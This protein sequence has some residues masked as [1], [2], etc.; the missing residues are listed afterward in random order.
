[1]LLE[2]VAVGSRAA[3]E[4]QIFAARAASSDPGDRSAASAWLDA[5]KKVKRAVDV[6]SVDQLLQMAIV[7][8]A[9]KREEAAT[10]LDYA[11]AIAVQL[12]EEGR[13]SSRNWGFTVARLGY[14]PAARFG[15]E[16]GSGVE[17]I[18]WGGATVELAR[19]GDTANVGRAL[20][21]MKLLVQHPEPT[22]SEEALTTVY[23]FSRRKAAEALADFDAA[24][25][26]QLG[27]HTGSPWDIANAYLTIADRAVLAKDG[28]TAQAALDRVEKIPDNIVEQFALAA[29]L[30]EQLDPQLAAPLWADALRRAL[31][32]K[33]DGF[34]SSP[35]VGMWA[36]YHARLESVLKHSDN[37]RGVLWVWDEASWSFCES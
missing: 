15:A 30:E 1:M 22:Y 14:E 20:A 6:Q 17:S 8:R 13:N 4:G 25:A 29:S 26:L 19:N 36:F 21:R 28:T 34:G 5:Q 9:L 18:F 27:P 12:K 2:K 3:L 35:S 24:A 11:T 23:E 7:A 10:W 32:Y 37:E 31:L 33:K 16:L